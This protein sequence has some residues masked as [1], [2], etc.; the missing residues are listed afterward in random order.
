ML[1]DFRVNLRK[2]RNIHVCIS[3]D[4]LNHNSVSICI[5][6]AAKSRIFTLD[7]G[8]LVVRFYKCIR[9]YSENMKFIMQK[10]GIL[11]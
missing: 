11:S 2:S 6:I 10:L 8:N 1:F 3:D 4:W 7:I 9:L 5:C